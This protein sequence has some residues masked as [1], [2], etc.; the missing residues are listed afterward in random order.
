MKNIIL[1]LVFVALSVN[2]SGQKG[3]WNKARSIN[4]IEAYQE[5]YLKYPDSKYAESAYSHMID[6][7]YKECQRIHEIR[8]YERLIEK[9][10]DNDS[11]INKAKKVIDEFGQRKKENE[12]MLAKIE[13]YE[14]GVLTV[15]QFFNDGWNPIDA[16]LGRDGIIWARKYVVLERGSLNI[17]IGN[18]DN[19]GFPIH[20]RITRNYMKFFNGFVDSQQS[21]PDAR[22]KGFGE[23]HYPIIHCSVI[24]INGLLDTI[25]P[26][27]LKDSEIFNSAYTK[28]YSD[29]IREQYMGK[30]QG[31]TIKEGELTFEYFLEIETKIEDGIKVEAEDEITRFK[32]EGWI[33]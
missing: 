24:F 16:Y 17:K 21:T 7:E 3:K 26:Y 23:E 4:T 22:F 20:D 1:I 15:E 19:I 29:I 13:K 27:T 28:T 12:L 9:Y 14:I 31:A 8:M 33:Y 2:A 25:V 30:P 18:I 6:L 10:P 11:L 32:F 5:F